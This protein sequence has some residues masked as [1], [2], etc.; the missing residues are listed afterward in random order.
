MKDEADILHVRLEKLLDL[1]RH[2]APEDRTRIERTIRLASQAIQE[3]ARAREE[4]QRAALPKQEA[5]A[6][7][8]HQRREQVA[9]P[10]ELHIIREDSS[11]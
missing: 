10:A 3:V 9:L 8:V 7:M 4:A 11:E 1:A 2:A 6:N 5:E